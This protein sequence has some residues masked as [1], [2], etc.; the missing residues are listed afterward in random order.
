MIGGLGGFVVVKC[1]IV[2]FL[3]DFRKCFWCF[4]GLE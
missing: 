2:V 1:F 4:G 3:R